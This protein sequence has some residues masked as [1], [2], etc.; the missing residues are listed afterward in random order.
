LSSYSWNFSAGEEARR[1]GQ[2]ADDVVI[3]ASATQEMNGTARALLLAAATGGA[4]ACE[5]SIG[6]SIA[7]M[8]PRSARVV[9]QRSVGDGDVTVLTPGE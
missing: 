3:S 4:A 8:T 6:T 1:L 7:L 2:A 5:R 9:V